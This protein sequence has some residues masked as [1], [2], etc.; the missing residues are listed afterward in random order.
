MDTFFVAKRFAVVGA[1]LDRTKYGN[2][3]LRWYLDHNLPVTPVNPKAEMIEGQQCVRSLAELND[4][5]VSVSVIT[6]PQVSEQILKEAVRLGIKHI[7]F[8]PGSEPRGFKEVAA[9]HSGV[10]GNGPCVL[11]DGPSLLSAKL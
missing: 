2:K 11:V 6:P 10:I 5:G 8:Q 9:K 1:S 7:W 3:V 4:P